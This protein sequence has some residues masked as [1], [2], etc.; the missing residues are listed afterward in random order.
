MAIRGRLTK[1]KMASSMPADAPAYHRKPFHYRKARWLRFDYETDPEAAA[2]LVPAPLELPQTATASLTFADYTW[3]TLGSYRETILSIQALDGGEELPYL[4]YLMLNREVPV[5][6]G[7]EVYGFPKKM[8]VVEFFEEED[9]MAAYVERPRGIRICSGV[10]RPEQS[11]GSPLPAGSSVD[12][13]S[14]RILPSP[15][16]DQEHSLV[17]IIRTGFVVRSMEVWTGP[18]NCH[19]T[20]ASALDPWHKLPVK[21]MLGCSYLIFDAELAPGKVLYTL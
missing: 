5:L 1:E 17:E 14:L 18:G 21:R 7:R 2:E 11:V 16:R 10:M 15:E 3:S 4:A 19:F 12:A 6:V 8:G 13:L 20:G 9:L